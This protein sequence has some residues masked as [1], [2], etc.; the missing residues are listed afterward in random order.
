MARTK[1]K[2][3]QLAIQIGHVIRENRR[4]LGLTQAA[5]AERL[6]LEAETISRM[7]SGTRLPSLEKLVEISEELR[8]PI[9][10]FFKPISQTSPS[11]D[12]NLYTDRL[13][14]VIHSVS[15]AGK[16]FL[17]EIAENYARSH[18]NDSPRA[19]E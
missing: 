6:K 8:I 16:L 9:T 3:P 15:D 5:L 1:R 12:V 10:T 17:L 19:A 11:T 18:Q 14:A 4:A 2:N 7:E 13:E